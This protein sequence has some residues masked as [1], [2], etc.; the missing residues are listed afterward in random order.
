MIGFITTLDSKR[1][2]K[3]Y[4]DVLGFKVLRE[5]H[6]GLVLKAGG[7]TIRISPVKEFQSAQYTVLG[8]EV[9]QIDDVASHLKAR[10]VVFERYPWMKQDALGIWDSPSGDK[11]AWFRDPDG[12]VLSISHCADI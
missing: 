8:W 4:E 11:V 7:N 3:F 2:R 5:D 9:E 10:G 1:A 12:N 6:L